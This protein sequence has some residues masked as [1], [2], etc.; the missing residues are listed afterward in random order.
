MSIRKPI[1]IAFLFSGFFHCGAS[2]GDDRKLD[3]FDDLLEKNAKVLNSKMDLELKQLNDLANGTTG[4]I[5]SN[6]LPGVKQEVNE[7]E[8]TVEAIWGLRGQEVAEINYKGRR[9]PVSMSDP[10]IS[11]I[12][13]WKLDSIQQYQ[14]QLVKLSGHSVVQRKTI[15][16]DWVGGNQTPAVPSASVPTSEPSNLSIPSLIAPPMR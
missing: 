4:G 7:Q 9:I 6:P 15:M 10:F 5:G 14:I 11:Q 12:D 1:L 13:G 2:I 3:T 8:P 16:F